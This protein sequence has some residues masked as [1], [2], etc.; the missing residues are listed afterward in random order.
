MTTE[1]KNYKSYSLRFK[2]VGPFVVAKAR[3]LYWNDQEKAFAIEFLK[4][5]CR[6]ISLKDI[7]SILNGDASLSDD[8]ELIYEPD[9]KFKTWLKEHIEYLEANCHSIAGRYVEK[10]MLAEYIL[11]ITKPLMYRMREYRSKNATGLYFEET[12]HAI[13]QN[14]NDI[15]TSILCSAGIRNAQCTGYSEFMRE[16]DRITDAIAGTMMDL[17]GRTSLSS[18]ECKLSEELTSIM[19]K[20]EKTIPI[21]SKQ[22]DPLKENQ[23][24]GDGAR[25][26][27]DLADQLHLILILQREKQK[28]IISLDEYYKKVNP[29]CLKLVSQFVD[30]ISIEGI[31][32]GTEGELFINLVNSITELKQKGTSKEYGS[33]AVLL[34]ERVRGFLHNNDKVCKMFLKQYPIR[35]NIADDR[36]F[37][38]IFH[39]L[40]NESTDHAKSALK[41]YLRGI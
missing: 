38:C 14:R 5:S 24:V 17:P 19:M 28:G 25:F 6:E 9:L 31:P 10:E 27:H 32:N 37:V 35:G 40:M 26:W 29:G 23:L 41:A 2:I 30:A 1:N 13:S 7:T 18:D 16:L 3:E 12:V 21:M 15:L 36:D 8:M 33:S 11:G 4:Q 20:K 39:D 22:P 34:L